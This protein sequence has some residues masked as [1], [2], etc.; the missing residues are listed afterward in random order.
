MLFV[1]NIGVK[2]AVVALDWF[3]AGCRMI[4]ERG[5]AEHFD[6]WVRLRQAL[7]PDETIEE[8]RRYAASLIDRPK[9][10]IVYLARE[11][12]GNIIAF[13]EATLRRDYVN[14][15][16]TSPV[17]F[18]EGLY[19]EAPYRGRGLARLLN[20]ALEEWAA[21]LG[22]TEFASDV[23]LHNESGQRAHKALGYE[24]TERVVFYA[25]RLARQ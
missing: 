21:G 11:Q 13:A 20:K 23:L 17:G 22:C 2:F 4:I 1:R 9:D 24:E 8:H 3:R 14:G 18:L 15:C 6:D 12:D 25:K 19:V 7:W 16:S 5:T 10:A